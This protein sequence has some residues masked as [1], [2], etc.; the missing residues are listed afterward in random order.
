VK[1]CPKCLVGLEERAEKCPLCGAPA[2]TELP[3]GRDR[4][5]EIEALGKR[6]P[7]TPEVRDAD[8][9]EKLKP[10]DLRK[11]IVELLSV[12]LGIILVMTF[13]ID[14]LLTRGLS[15]SRYTSIV[16]VV[17]WLAS[18]MPLIL[19]RHPWLV[20]SVLAPALVLAVMLWLV[21]RM[22]LFVNVALPITL[23]I[24]GLVAASG[25]L[26]SRQKVKGLNAVGIILT[27]IAIACLGLDSCLS[28]YSS[29][30][31]SCSWSLVVAISTIPVAGFFFYLH[32][33]IMS[34]ASLKK[35][36]RL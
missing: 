14:F 30:R 19:W 1:Y 10:E 27:A 31:I 8:I 34:R 15:W 25:T 7:F 6:E 22:A 23:L 29:G 12:S 18:A 17:I 16:L 5:R 4:Q 35:L 3:G 26:A 20:F 28:L 11:V 33:R 21:P 24:E 32:Y 2:V 36:F 9:G 13:I